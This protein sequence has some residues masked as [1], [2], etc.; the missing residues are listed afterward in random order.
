MRLFD[1][2]DA[3]VLML[4]T[5]TLLS[6]VVMLVGIYVGSLLGGEG[7]MVLGAAV[8][9]LALSAVTFSLALRLSGE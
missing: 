7:G 6:F 4:I 8:S 5:F 2:Y 9:L 1:K 3:P